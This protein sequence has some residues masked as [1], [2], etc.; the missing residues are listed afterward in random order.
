MSTPIYICIL[1]MC[2]ARECTIFNPTFPFRS[3]SFS[4]IL[5][6]SA[7]EH[8]HF[9]VFAVPET[10]LFEISLPTAGLFSRA[11]RARSESPHFHTATRPSHLSSLRSPAF[12]TL[13]RRSGVSGRPEPSQTRHTLRSGDPHF[14]TRAP[15]ARSGDQHFYARARSGAPHCTPCRGTY[16]P[17][18]GVSTPPPP[19]PRVNTTPVLSLH[20]DLWPWESSTIQAR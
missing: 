5:K 16:L 12:F 4:Q 6:Y 8:H 1:G 3:M 13:P 20:L 2:R 10:I 15:R 14:H 17:K 19:P 18:F 9:T 7:P 11:P